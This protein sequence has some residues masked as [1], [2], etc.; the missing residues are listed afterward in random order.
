MEYSTKIV[1][2]C[3]AC[4]SISVLFSAAD[5][6]DWVDKA[7]IRIPRS[8][9]SA[10][11]M[12]NMIVLA[13]GCVQNQICPETSPVCYCPEITNSTEAYFPNSNSWKD[14]ADM[15]IPRFRHCATVVGNNMYV[16]G[17][18]DINDV[19][20]N[21]VDV[22]NTVSGE[23]T[24][25]QPWI[26]STSDCVAATIGNTVY[27]IGGYTQD[28]TSLATVWTLDSTN[29]NLGWQTGQVASLNTSRGDHCGFALGNNIH[30][31]GGFSSPD[32]CEPLSS[33]E[34][35]DLSS[36]TWIQEQPL[37]SPRGDPTCGINHGA[38]HVIGGEQ[39]SNVTFCSKYD[40]PIRDVEYYQNGYWYEE[41]PYPDDTFRFACAT[42]QSTLYIFGG[43]GDLNVTTLMYPILNHTHSLKDLGNSAATIGRSL[44]LLFAALI[45][46]SL[47]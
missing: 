27:A 3:L 35:Y 1:L 18:R 21:E 33:Y 14:L 46:D 19:I 13:G 37:H 34:M 25:L 45:I 24:T 28:Y 39:K 7:P 29:I 12:G 31:I 40:V 26:N 23:W 44:L 30:I 17:G 15:P 20:I 2:L 9:H 42:Y 36:N 38:F 47:L 5:K 10:L 8:D 22:Y 11:T 4:L 6:I 32:F 41:T 16:M 43:Q